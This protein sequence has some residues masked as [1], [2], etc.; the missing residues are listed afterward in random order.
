VFSA[1][2]E[3]NGP[4]PIPA[5]L[6]S[7]IPI[8]FATSGDPVGT[9]AIASLARPGGNVTGLSTLAS[10]TTGKRLEL[11]REVAPQSFAGW[12]S[13]AM[14]AIPSSWWSWARFRRRPARSVSKFD[15]LEIRRAQDIAPAVEALKGRTDALYVCTDA[16]A[17]T[18][19]ISNQ[20]P[21]GRRAT[22]DDARVS[23]TTSKR[24]V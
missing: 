12:R 19:R 7:I 21:G 22:A 24:D 23:G 13:W 3:V 9:S 15:T 5:D 20:H 17:N 1:V 4:S 2:C 8:V 18:N 14:S 16:L 6:A 10:D 11:L